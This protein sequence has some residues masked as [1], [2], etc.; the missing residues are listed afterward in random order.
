MRK[1]SIK[2]RLYAAVMAM[3]MTVTSV[4]LV[5][6]V[7][8]AKASEE[9]VDIVDLF[10][11]SDDIEVVDI[12]KS[13]AR[14][15][16]ESI[17][18]SIFP[19]NEN[20]ASYDPRPL[21]RVTSVK[22]QG[23]Y[24]L[25]WDYAANSACESALI[26]QGLEK[27]T[28]DLSE[29]Y[30]AYATYKNQKST[31]G[32]VD[33]CNDGN[34]AHSF[35]TKIN[36]DYIGKFALES[37][38][39]MPSEIKDSYS[40]SDEQLDNYKYKVS[41][42]YKINDY[43]PSQDTIKKVKHL[44]AE[45]GGATWCYAQATQ[46]MKGATNST[47]DTNYYCPTKYTTNH[48]VEVVGWDDNY[49]ASNFINTPPGN[50][51]WLVK[52]SWGVGTNCKAIGIDWDKYE[53][54][55]ETTGTG[56]MWI[57][58]YNDCYGDWVNAMEIVPKDE[59]TYERKTINA[60]IGETVDLDKICKEK[61]TQWRVYNSNNSYCC[62]NTAKITCSSF[63]QTQYKGY[64][65]YGNLVGEYIIN[66]IAKE[67]AEYS[68][69]LLENT[70]FD[71]QNE[72]RIK[73]VNKKFWFIGLERD[74]LTGKP[75]GYIKFNSKLDGVSVKSQ[76]TLSD[77]NVLEVADDKLV[78]KDFG[79][80]LITAT[81]CDEQIT[82]GKTYSYEYWINVK[83]ICSS[84]KWEDDTESK[85]IDLTV[86]DTYKI[87]GIKTVPEKQKLI[88]ES[89]DETVVKVSEEGVVETVGSGY[90]TVK[91]RPENNKKIYINLCVFVEDKIQEPEYN[92]N[93]DTQEN[94]IVF[95]DENGNVIPQNANTQ[96][97]IQQGEVVVPSPKIN[98]YNTSYS[99]NEDTDNYYH[100][101]NKASLKVKGK[102]KKGKVKIIFGAL[103]ADEYEIEVATNKSFTKGVKY[104]STTKTS[105][106]IRKLKKNKKYYV[107]VRGV[108][109]DY[110]GKWSKVKVL[111]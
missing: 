47:T 65:E 1:K 76:I 5:P 69:E 18:Q 8:N 38:F 35:N 14:L 22:D 98:Y 13:T 62:L 44:I 70:S 43:E 32:F 56:Y 84:I 72:V 75:N 105:Y 51:A 82:G 15:D 37:V 92:N 52:N 108:N 60:T 77:N 20:D 91:I 73:D 54:I 57:S 66:V 4:G 16:N 64:D 99:F 21:G 80:T 101:V 95:Y 109:D 45:F 67:N 17:V 29:I 48:A 89:S 46:Y 90:S 110:D 10:E 34:N 87:D 97:M 50:G 36:D 41:R 33:F 53:G 11:E 27:N 40:L 93:T 28:V 107:R 100:S 12:S 106:T 42:V 2:T 111:K 68:F 83:E 104:Y 55:Y 59:E 6:V 86:G 103:Y 63:G 49:A 102:I 71:L 24:G 96:N 25:C 81:F 58:Y 9:P 3:L 85:T 88:F 7:T 61:V 74:S 26:Y 23:E 94:N 39:P 79:S 78:I 31:K 19:I 30:F